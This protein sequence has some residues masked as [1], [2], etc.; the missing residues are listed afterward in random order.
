MVS[1]SKSVIL[2]RFGF[3]C[4]IFV[5]PTYRRASRGFRWLY[6][7]VKNC[8]F[9]IELVFI[10]KIGEARVKNKMAGHRRDF[11]QN[12][13]NYYNQNPRFLFITPLLGSES[14][15]G[16]C[17]RQECDGR[18]LHFKSEL[19]NEIR[20]PNARF[21]VRVQTFFNEGRKKWGQ[22]VTEKIFSRISPPYYLF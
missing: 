13:F 20:R 1:G 10:W 3:F 6:V 17:G 21:Q 7:E 16:G 11:I 14:V 8:R 18:N 15:F 12:R 9:T 5:K 22:L 19:K 2:S 4:D